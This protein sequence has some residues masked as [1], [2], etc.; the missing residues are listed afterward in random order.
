MKK[1]AKQLGE[2]NTARSCVIDSC[3]IST[4]LDCVSHSLLLLHVGSETIYSHV[5]YAKTK[6]SSMSTDTTVTTRRPSK[7][8]RSSL[9]AADAWTIVEGDEGDDN[10]YW[11]TMTGQTSWTLPSSAIQ[12]TSLE[13]SS[14]LESSTR[15]SLESSRPSLDVIGE[16]DEADDDDRVEEEED[17]DDDDDSSSRRRTLSQTRPVSSPSLTSSTMSSTTS[18]TTSSLSRGSG[19][20]RSQ[21]L[22]ENHVSA[23][24]GMAEERG[25]V[26][27]E[28]WLMKR[29]KTG[30]F[31]FFFVFFFVECWDTYL[32][33][34]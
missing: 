25:R 31:F 28:G 30:G 2:K 7:P 5:N 8:R 14:M 12:T 6:T 33:K 16:E 19:L 17:D 18:S 29:T 26:R 22:I 27:K 11:N 24:G 13:S 1:D 34:I 23:F 3:E 9:F 4:A 15:G 20:M 10:Y 32:L 21:S